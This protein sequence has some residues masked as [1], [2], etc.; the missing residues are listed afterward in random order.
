VRWALQIF[1]ID[2][3]FLR[4]LEAYVILFHHIILVDVE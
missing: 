2:G 3:S 1:L 4:A